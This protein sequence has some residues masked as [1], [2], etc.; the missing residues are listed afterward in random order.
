MLIARQDVWA[1]LAAG[2]GVGVAAHTLLSLRRHYGKLTSSSQLLAG[3]ELGG[4]TCVA[5]IVRN[6]SPTS[7]LYRYEVATTTPDET[8]GAITA[9]LEMQG[10]LAAIGVASFG[11]VD[12]DVKSVTYGS[13]T[14]TPKEHWRMF[15]LLDVFKPYGEKFSCPIAFDTDVNAPAMAELAH[16][17]HG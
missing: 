9:W 16:G 12:L 14:N 1:L 7:I 4:T 11:P 17:L 8:L 3:V 5:A 15:R 6:D 2:V 10:P 13:I